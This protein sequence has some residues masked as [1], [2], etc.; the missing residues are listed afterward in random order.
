M[1]AIETSHALPREIRVQS[2]KFKDCLEPISEAGGFPIKVVDSL[3]ALAEARG[4]L[5][6]MSGGFSES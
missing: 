6:R 3:P 1:K 2:R 5:L 4:E